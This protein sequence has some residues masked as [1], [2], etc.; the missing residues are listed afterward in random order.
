M[1]DMLLSDGNFFKYRHLSKLSDIEMVALSI[2]SKTL[3][4]DSENLLFSKS[5]TEYQEDF[6]I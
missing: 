3:W 1:A 6:P 5:R 2:T 4:I